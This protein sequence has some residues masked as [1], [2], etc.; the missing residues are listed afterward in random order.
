MKLERSN[1]VVP[2]YRGAAARHVGLC[3]RLH[4]GSVKQPQ[5]I[6]YLRTLKHHLRGRKAILLWDRLPAHCGRA[7]QDYVTRNRSWLT[8]K[9]FPPYAPELNPVEYFWSHL[10]GTDMANFIGEDLS[11]ARRRAVRAGARVRRQPNL[12]R[13]FLNHSG[14]F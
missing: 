12:G 10:S 5:I 1:C 9:Y 13:G 6:A 8:T 4:P 3:L 2:Q 11:A 14:L 7:V